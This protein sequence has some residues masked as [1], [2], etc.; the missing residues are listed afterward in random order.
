MSIEI[1]SGNSGSQDLMRIYNV[2]KTKIFLTL[3][4]T[5]NGVIRETREHGAPGYQVHVGQER[6]R[7]S[8]VVYVYPRHVVSAK[9]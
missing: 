4:R 2:I 6:L 1:V 5:I 7:D 3:P 9:K 8:R